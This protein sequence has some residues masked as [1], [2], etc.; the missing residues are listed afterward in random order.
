MAKNLPFYQHRST[1]I[2]WRRIFPV[3]S[4]KQGYVEYATYNYNMECTCYTRL[5]HV[6]FVHIRFY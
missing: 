4:V 3:P 5:G 2:F 1:A 6:H